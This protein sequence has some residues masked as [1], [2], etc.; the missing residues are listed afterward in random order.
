M[1]NVP[2]GFGVTAQSTEV[3]RNFDAAVG[4]I[5]FYLM[6]RV[7]LFYTNQMLVS[8][9]VMKLFLLEVLFYFFSIVCF[10][11]IG[12]FLVVFWE[13]ANW[14]AMNDEVLKILEEKDWEYDEPINLKDFDM[15]DLL[16]EEEVEFE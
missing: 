6:Y 5:A 16:A 8:I 11:K 2:L 10:P 4:I 3:I 14:S 15:L 7:S 9:F 1:N 13:K 12:S